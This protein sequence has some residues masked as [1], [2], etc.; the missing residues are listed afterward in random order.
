MFIQSQA[1]ALQIRPWSKTSH[2]VTWLTPDYGKVVTVVK[3]ACRPKSAFLGQYDL[4]Y[5]CDLL[6]YRRDHD[7]VHAIRECEPIDLREPLRRSWRQATAAA[8]LAD[9]TARVTPEHQS[10]QAL[11]SLF[12]QTLDGLAYSQENPSHK[13]ILGYEINLLRLL[14]VLPD[15]TTCPLC[16]TPDRTWLRFSLPS[17]RFLCKHTGTRLPNEATLPVHRDVQSLFL[18]FC[19]TD[20]VFSMDHL[21]FALA[22][23]K[24]DVSSNLLFGLSRFLGMFIAFHLDVPSAVRRVALEML[25]ANHTQQT[26][27]LETSQ[28]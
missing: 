20:N 15:F 11:Y 12:S 1:I 25:N 18:S 23:N 26:A 24:N 4:F 19:G 27:L 2:M 10:N 14:G 3:G 16:H 6:F 21:P 28:T 17:G 5:T 9:L 7:G 8:Y 22:S 13:L